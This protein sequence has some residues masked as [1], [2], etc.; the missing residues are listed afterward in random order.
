VASEVLAVEG[1]Q[2]D[3]T[4][5]QHQNSAENDLHGH[6]QPAPAGLGRLSVMIRQDGDTLGLVGSWLGREA[7]PANER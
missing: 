7:R 1:Q 6:G 5:G 2:Q 4:E 3:R